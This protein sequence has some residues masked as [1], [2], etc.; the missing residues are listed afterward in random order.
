MRLRGKKGVGEGVGEL[1]FRLYNAIRL[2]KRL[3]GVAQRDIDG[4][5][6]ADA[7]RER[8]ARVV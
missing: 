8:Y 6:N 2:R 4:L 7:A 3:I 5:V 1:T